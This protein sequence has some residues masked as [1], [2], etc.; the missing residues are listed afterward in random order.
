VVVGEFKNEMQHGLAFRFC[1][2]YAPLE[3]VLCS[4]ETKKKKTRK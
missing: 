3:I 4:K 1:G 2:C